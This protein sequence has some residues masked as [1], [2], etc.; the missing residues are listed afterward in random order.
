MAG[1]LELDPVG[2]GALHPGPLPQLQPPDIAWKET[3]PTATG[4]GSPPSRN[5]VDR[6]FSVNSNASLLGGNQTATSSKAREKR[7][8]PT[9]PALTQYSPCFRRSLRASSVNTCQ[10]PRFLTLK[11][12]HVVYSGR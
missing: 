6:P 7:A 5:W 3:L 2:D 11:T 8:H 1:G 4:R 9:S 10:A 12:D